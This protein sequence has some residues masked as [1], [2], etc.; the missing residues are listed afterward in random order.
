MASV[1]AMDRPSRFW[2]WSSAAA[3]AAIAV[4]AA[5]Y[6]VIGYQGDRGDLLTPAAGDD[7]VRS[8]TTLGDATIVLEAEHG[9]IGIAELLEVTLIVEGPAGSLV[10][11]PKLNGEAG[12]FDV[13]SR[14]AIGPVTIDADRRRWM[15][16]YLLAPLEV[17]TLATPPMTVILQEAVRQDR[18]ET[19]RIDVEP[20]AVEVTTVLPPDANIGKP[21][22]ILGP[23][24]LPEP[25]RPLLWPWIAGAAL[26]LAVLAYIVRRLSRRRPLEDRAS[27][28]PAEVSALS[29]LARLEGAYSADDIEGFHIRIAAILRDYAERRFDLPASYLTTQEVAAVVAAR[30]KSQGWGGRLTTILGHCDLV[31]FA[32]LRPSPEEMDQTRAAAA[33]FIRD[34][35]ADSEEA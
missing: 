24:S 26:A 7:R 13:E 15:R 9:T 34:T 22:G 29:A 32:R 33:A 17:G 21:R 1:T 12:S 4:A 25:E 28:E 2:W 19:R 35:S 30:P 11:L 8:E 27:D 6:V 18:I 16:T 5:L 23:V 20:L 14:D 3:V 31:K 10:T